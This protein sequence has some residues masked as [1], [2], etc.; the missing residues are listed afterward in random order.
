[1]SKKVIQIYNYDIVELWANG[2]CQLRL[3]W[4]QERETI[5]QIISG[6][7]AMECTGKF[8][9]E[10]TRIDVKVEPDIVRALREEGI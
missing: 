4:E 6:K 7:F 9:M 10:C 8:T 5:D 3:T 2:K 1:M